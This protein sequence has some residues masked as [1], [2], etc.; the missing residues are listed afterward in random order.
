MGTGSS[1]AADNEYYEFSFL[2][3][4]A[5]VPPQNPVASGITAS[6]ATIAWTAGTGTGSVVEYG[7]SGFTP[8]SGTSMYVTDTSAVL[9]SLTAN[10]TYDVYVK[11]SCTNNS[12]TWA[13]P[14]TFT[15]LCSSQISGTVTI[16]PGLPASSTNFQTFNAL[17]TEINACGIAGALTVN[18]S[19]GTYSEQVMFMD[20]VGA[21]AASPIIINGGGATIS[22]DGANTQ[23]ATIQLNGTDH[24]TIKNLTVENTESSSYGWGIHL[25]NGADS[26]TVDSCTININQ[27]STSSSFAGIISSNSNTST[28]SYG[29][30][31]NYTMVSNTTINGGYYGVRFNGGGSST[32]LNSGNMV[33]NCTLTENRT[34]TIYFIYQDGPTAT[35]NSCSW[36]ASATSSYGIYLNNSR[37]GNVQRNTINGA[38]TYGLYFVSNN[39]TAQSPTQRVL[40]ANNMVTALSSGDGIYLSGSDQFDIFHNSVTAENDQALW[41]NSSSDDF[42]VRNNIFSISGSTYVIDLDAAPDNTTDVLDYNIYYNSGTGSIAQVVSTNYATLAAW[43]TGD[44]NQNVSSLEG[45]PIFAS[46]TDLHVIGSL[47]NDVGDNTVGITVD[48]DGETRPAAGST[49]VDIGADEYT[50]SSCSPPSGLAFYNVTNNSAT[51]YWTTGGASNWIIQYGLSGFTPGSG[52][53]ML[54]TN[55]T[56]DITGLM[57]QT[58]YDV[59]VKD[60][61]GTTTSFWNGPVSFTTLCDPAV[62]PY[63][64]N[65]DSLALVSPYTDLPACW[66]P[67]TGPDFWDV[68]N[69]ITNT[70]H[71]YL[72]NIGDHTSGTTNYMW[73]DA[74]SDITGNAMITGLID[75][76]ALTTPFAGFWFASDNTTNTINHTIS[77]DAWDGTGWVNVTTESGNFTGWVEVAGVVPANVP[78]TTKFRIQ[79]IADPNGTSSTYYFNDLGVD[80]FFV[81]EAPN[82]PP[83]SGLSLVSVSNSDATIT[84]TPGGT[85]TNWMIQYDTA[86]FTPGTGNFMASSN[87]TAT[88]SGLMAQTSYD[89]YVKD[90]CSATSTSAWIGPLSITTLCNPFTAPYTESFDTTVI[91]DCWS[92]SA[93]S[94]GPWLFS[95]STNSV[96]CNA[97]TDHTGN[98][99]SYTWMDQS[100]SDAGVSLIMGAVDVSALTV[101]YLEF[102][103]W[104]CGAGYSPPNLTF[105]EAWN[106]SSW[107]TIDSLTS[108]T[109]GWEKFSYV[110][111]SYTYGSNL[112]QIRFRAESGGSGSDFYGDNALDDITIKEAPSCPQP[113]SLGAFNITANSADVFLDNRWCFVSSN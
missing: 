41:I 18:V 110:L 107:T 52:M 65:F 64:E 111:S 9:T 17:A 75:M 96:N 93:V 3:A 59:Y 82:C 105:I 28:G 83:P 109:V 72:P 5:C 48:I 89:V 53:F 33:H 40:V 81:M 13:G 20:I 14:A 71:T 67:Q 19:P 113:T 34:Y 61:C 36:R 47:A 77:L 32:S 35:D 51:A 57:S 11:D 80:D 68:T 78:D 55:D 21:S 103:Y 73:I 54:A 108:A 45:D 39:L 63:M 88:I 101:P 70:G 92:Q 62:A 87:D 44:V 1:G 58:T 16:N 4:G 90:S 8:G 10:T 31:A 95:G 100:G 79:A 27:T 29:N 46:A 66:E 43:Q 49:I 91:P 23:N 112:V 12:S 24:M 85:A 69:D 106:G 56:T 60:S 50:A 74:S 38:R 99:G 97:A 2:A 102:Y 30:N 76:S 86:G 84:W 22:Y 104:M 7:A 6:G 26:N 98:G 25:I 15:T 94:G 37:H 42:D